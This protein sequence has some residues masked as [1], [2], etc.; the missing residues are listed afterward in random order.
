[1]THVPMATD[2]RLSSGQ[3][4]DI[5]IIGAGLA[6]L[7][8]GLH[9]V[10]AS[11]RYSMLLVDKIVPWEHPIQ[12]AEAVGRLGLEE[13]IEVKKSWIRQQII[14]ASFHAPDDTTV[15]YTDKNG[16]YI[17][18]RAAMQRD[19]T[20]ELLLSGV[21][22]IFNRRVVRIS[23]MES[24]RRAVVFSDGTTL[25]GRVIID[26]SGPVACL[27][28]EDRLAW[29]PMDLEPA[30]FVHAEGDGLPVDTVHIYA[31]RD[32]A[33]GG[34]GWA[35]PRGRGSANIGVLVG[36]PFKSG[37]NIRRRLDAFLARHF[38]A[39][40]I[41]NCFSGAIPCG[42]KTGPAAAAGLIKAGDA[43]STVNPISRAGISEA[44]LSGAL[45]G[46]HALLMLEVKNENEM[47]RIVT[48]YEN[49]WRKKRGRQHEKL[50]RAKHSL[51]LVPDAD[52]NRA[53]H[54]LADVPQEELTMLK[55]FG[56]ALARFPRLAWS[57]RHLM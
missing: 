27:G 12:C 52:Y 50:A 57:L 25:Y 16:G 26:A 8:A 24:Q 33:P 5:V 3:R 21:T 17:I 46:D 47:R 45:A 41:V 28:K 13:A 11:Q 44:L 56:S 55:I 38:P 22:C 48:S 35:F 36:S 30:Y 32:L 54:A 18:D 9:A 6:G 14:R 2:A 4:F 34:Y 49:A 31:S 53:A 29:K 1:M 19:C 10:R 15:T 51:A 43:A 42:Y 40:T 20:R 7:N 39:I 23:R 37:V